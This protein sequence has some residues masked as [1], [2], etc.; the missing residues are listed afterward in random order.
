VGTAMGA[1]ERH[2]VGYAV[3]TTVEGEVLAQDADG[4]CV[5]GRQ[6]VGQVDRLPERAQVTPGQRA[7]PDAGEVEIRGRVDAAALRATRIHCHPLISRPVGVSVTGARAD[8]S[9]GVK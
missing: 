1:T 7:R 5:A 6:V 8:K 2:R 4:L 9:I 3:L